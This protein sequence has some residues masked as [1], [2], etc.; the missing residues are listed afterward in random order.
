MISRPLLNALC[1][2]AT[3]VCDK[4]DFSKH[5]YNMF[6]D[7]V[8]IGNIISVIISRMFVFN[9][10]CKVSSHNLCGTKHPTS[11]FRI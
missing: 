6:N 1:H 7:S 3:C 2:S 4:V 5:F 10:A 8:A 11:S 9:C